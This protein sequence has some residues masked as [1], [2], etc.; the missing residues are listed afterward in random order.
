MK[1]ISGFT[2]GLVL[3]SA[4]FVLETVHADFDSDA[5][6]NKRAKTVEVKPKSQMFQRLLMM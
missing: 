3:I 5:A 4:F 1:Y 6:L 2:A